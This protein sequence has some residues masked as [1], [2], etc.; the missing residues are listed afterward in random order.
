MPVL[1]GMACSCPVITT[2]ASSLPEVGGDAVIYVDP[3]SVDEMHQA[4]LDVQNASTRADL[5]P[6]LRQ[7]ENFSWSRMAREVGQR[8]AQW[9]VEF[10]AHYRYKPRSRDNS[11]TRSNTPPRTGMR[12][13]RARWCLSGAIVAVQRV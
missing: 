2:R 12:R 9:A 6:G 13:G 11:I 7:A 4:L 3:D 1:E 10:T 5:V 8:L